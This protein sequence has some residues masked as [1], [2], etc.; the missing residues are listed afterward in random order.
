MTLRTSDP[1]A[2]TAGGITYQIYRE[3]FGSNRFKKVAD[4]G[5]HAPL[6]Q[7]MNTVLLRA[8]KRPILQLKTN[9]N[10]KRLR[11]YF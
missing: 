8:V 6:I 9:R 1:A 3:I 4:E 10:R 11:K 2:K 5:A 7:D